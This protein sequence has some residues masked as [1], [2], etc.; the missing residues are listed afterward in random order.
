M[1]SWWVTTELDEFGGFQRD[2]YGPY[3]AEAEAEKSAMTLSK[4]QELVA[5]TIFGVAG[6]DGER[7]A[8]FVKGRRYTS[9]GSGWFTVK[10]A[11]KIKIPTT[12][13]GHYPPT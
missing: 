9:G 1:S 2:W 12:A 13:N 3:P 11:P 8:E 10:P 7:F 6:R 4:T 5:E